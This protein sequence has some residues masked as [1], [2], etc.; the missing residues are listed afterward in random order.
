[1]LILGSIR[2]IVRS[3][4][5]RKESKP[6]DGVC[7]LAS[8]RRK[9]SFSTHESRKDGEN[10]PPAA[11]RPPP[12]A[13][14][15]KKQNRPRYR[16]NPTPA[17]PSTESTLSHA[18]R[19]ILRRVGACP[20]SPPPAALRPPPPAGGHKKQNRLRGAWPDYWSSLF[21]EDTRTRTRER[22]QTQCDP[23]LAGVGE[24]V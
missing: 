19:V 17:T 8:H 7:A 22:I 16:R 5:V 6:A 20:Y 12:P 4:T 24:S 9:K 23:S 2:N 18:E 11:L 21:G 3:Q 1:M 10:P 15:H 14:G 13:G